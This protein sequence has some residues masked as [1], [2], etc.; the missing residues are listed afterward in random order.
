MAT[1]FQPLAGCQVTADALQTALALSVCHLFKSSF[2]PTPSDPLAN[3][4]AAE[5]DYDAYA[6]KTMTAWNEPILSPGEGYM[7]VSPL[8]QFD[9]GV[10]DPVVGNVIGGC[11]LVDAAGKLRQTIIFTTP[12]PMQLAG[13]GIPVTITIQEPTQ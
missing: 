8:V 6:P 2:V 12:I 3:Y 4:T 1:Q 7:I 5:A 9:V 11:Y 10:T 13:Q